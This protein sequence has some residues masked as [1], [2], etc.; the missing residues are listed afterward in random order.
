M[1][2]LHI[3]A[4]RHLYGGAKQVAYLLKDLAE[5]AA[6]EHVKHY[7]VVPA[8]AELRH[9][10]L[11]DT[12]VIPIKMGGDMDLCLIL[13]LYRIIRQQ[14]I[15]L[16][17]C[18]SRRGADT[19][20]L[21]A[22]KLAGCKV[23]CVRRVDNP[24]RPWL[25]RLKYHAFDQVIC[26]SEGIRQVL[27]SQGVRPEHCQTIRS[28]VD[29][30]EF[31]PLDATARATFLA[32]FALPADAL[33]IANFAQM[34]ERKGQRLI[35]EAFAELADAHPQTYL[36][37]FGRGPQLANYQALARALKLEGRV[38]FPGFHNDLPSIMPCVDIVVHPAQMEGLGVAL[39]QTSAC[40]VPIIA[41]H[42]GGIPEIVKHGENGL[43]MNVDDKSALVTHLRHLMTADGYRQQLG[44]QGRQFA[45][46]ECA[47]STMSMAYRQLFRHHSRLV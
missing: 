37:L 34:I 35:L 44:Q 10:D 36:M 32:R 42:A 9:A 21:L 47:I 39:M 1:R 25:A 14:R 38:F 40:G 6:D 20:G 8:D 33:V 2:V 41:T 3:E 18:H 12:T 17:L 26:I 19:L 43:L 28:A 16:V 13:R 24:E 45:E 7:L 15:D 23:I 27:L 11:G 5:T 22:A 29:T 4:G 30:A 31:H 46:N